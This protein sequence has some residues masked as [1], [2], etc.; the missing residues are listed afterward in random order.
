MWLSV[1]ICK[2]FAVLWLG[3]DVTGA[4]RVYVYS[5]LWIL[6]NVFPSVYNTIAIPLGVLTKLLS[7]ERLSR[8]L[9]AF[10]LLVQAMGIKGVLTA[11]FIAHAVIFVCTYDL[12]RI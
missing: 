4:S 3:D 5:L 8:K 12:S 1:Y 6:M 10:L 2:W 9:G 7:T 11:T